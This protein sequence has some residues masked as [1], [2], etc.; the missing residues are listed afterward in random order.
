MPALP[1][2][3]V[4]L[5]RVPDHLVVPR[6]DAIDQLFCASCAEKVFGFVHC[7]YGVDND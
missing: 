1:L 2:V 3:P 6:V 5:L 7:T 4:L